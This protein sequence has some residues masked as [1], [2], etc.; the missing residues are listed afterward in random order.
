MKQRPPSDGHTAESADGSS[1]KLTWFENGAHAVV[2][3]I[4]PAKKAGVTFRISRAE[5][6]ALRAFLPAD[7][8]D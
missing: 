4:R 2:H 7:R 5:A 8:P 6:T 3:I 1:V